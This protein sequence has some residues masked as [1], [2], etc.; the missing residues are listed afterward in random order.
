V[1]VLT[2]AWLLALIM[3]PALTAIL[4]LL[5]IPVVVFFVWWSMRGAKHAQLDHLISLFAIGFFPAALAVLAVES[6][7][8]IMLGIILFLS[9]FEEWFESFTDNQKKMEH[10]FGYFVFLFATAFI[11]A[12]ICEESMKYLLTHRVQKWNRDF[13][14]WRGYCYLGAAATLGFSTIENIGYTLS[15]YSAASKSSSESERLLQALLTAVQRILVST[16]LHLSTAVLI[17]LLVAKKEVFSQPLSAF[18][19]LALPVLFHGAFNFGLLLIYSF[20]SYMG[21]SRSVGFSLLYCV[22]VLILV[23]FVVQR[24]YRDVRRL[25]EQRIAAAHVAVGAFEQV[26]ANENAG[27]D[28]GYGREDEENRYMGRNQE[29]K[30]VINDMPAA[31]APPME[32]LEAQSFPSSIPLSPLSSISIRAESQT[33]RLP[34]PTPLEPPEP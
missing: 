18:R 25:Y 32:D 5:A 14:D 7:I 20:E 22:S 3:A 11:V 23:G 10:T 21:E 9:E 19:I 28:H 6:F 24:V 26:V 13:K 29:A 34:V 12:G 4:T 27:E 8:T 30:F 15:S 17:A 1:A 16:P 33:P 31:S 2:F